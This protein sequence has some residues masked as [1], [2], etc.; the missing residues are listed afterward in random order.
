MRKLIPS[1]LKMSEQFTLR[2]SFISMVSKWSGLDYNLIEQ[3][4]EGDKI[5]VND[6]LKAS[7]VRCYYNGVN[8]A[9]FD[10]VDEKQYFLFKLAWS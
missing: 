4:Q 3:S 7:G 2:R 9:G 1:N 5:N 8:L 10:V 6:L